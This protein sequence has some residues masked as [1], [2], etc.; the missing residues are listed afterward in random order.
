MLARSPIRRSSWLYRCVPIVRRR[1]RDFI[2]ERL[3]TRTLTMLFERWFPQ[4]SNKFQ[5]MK[6]AL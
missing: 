2:S 4:C 1:E 5:R 6:T 3:P